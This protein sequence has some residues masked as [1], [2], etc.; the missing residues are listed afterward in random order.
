M[1]THTPH[2]PLHPALQRPLRRHGLVVMLG[3]LQILGWAT[4]FYLPAVLAASVAAENDWSLA[5]TMGGLAWGLLVAGACSPSVGRKIDRWGGGTI[6][7]AGSV[8]MGCGLIALALGYGPLAY[9]FA[10]T[11][12]GMGMA[13]GLYDAAFATLGRLCGEHTRS[14]ITGLTL[15]G[16]FASTLGWPLISALNAELGWRMTCVLLAAAHLC[17]AAPLHFHRVP[18]LHRVANPGGPQPT[19]PSSRL[20]PDPRFLRLAVLFTLLAFVMTSLS[21]HLLDLLQR[22]GLSMATAVA[23]GMMI[24]PAQVGARLLEFMVGRRWHP[25]WSAR[26]GLLLCLS[27]VLTL[28]YVIGHASSSALQAAFIAVAIYGAGNGLMTIARGTLP[29]AVFGPHRYGE[30]MGLLARP[31]LI[32]QASAPV[33]TALLLDAAGSTGL[34]GSLAVLLAISTGLIGLPLARA[35]KPAPCTTPAG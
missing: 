25:V 13:A 18:R 35:P 5:W 9:F 3:L 22:A 7:A 20:P 34:L 30:R 32:A 16:G 12:L 8:L 33:L 19:R 1:T 27:G 10:W 26:V 17:I 23:I 29:L 4:T 21:V 14:A 2:A 28:T 6:L 24:G 11:L 15:L 31:M